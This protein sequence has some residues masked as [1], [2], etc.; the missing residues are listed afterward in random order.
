MNASGRSP[1]ASMALTFVMS[2]EPSGPTV[3]TVWNL[4]FTPVF[5][6]NRV[7]KLFLFQ[8]PVTVVS[9]GTTTVNVFEPSP[10]GS[11]TVAFGPTYPSGYSTPFVSGPSVALG[12]LAAPVDGVSV[13]ASLSL[14]QAARNAGSAVAPTPT[15]T[16]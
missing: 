10:N 1:A 13:A 11:F 7:V 5:L 9:C 14:L 2:C 3:T 4:M 16:P 15:P 6:A 8:S 12:A